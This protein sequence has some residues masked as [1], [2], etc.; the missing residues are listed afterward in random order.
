MTEKA[1]AILE[2]ASVR[3]TAAARAEQL[4]S[5]VAMTLLDVDEAETSVARER[6][7]RDELVGQAIELGVAQHPNAA[8]KSPIEH[9]MVPT[10]EWF[11]AIVDI[12]S[13]IAPRVRQLEANEQIRV[14]SGTK[15]FQV[16]AH[17]LV[18]QARDCRQVPRRN[19]QLI[20][21]IP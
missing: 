5:E 17:E 1:S 14:G 2:R 20:R 19:Q 4:V 13:R 9:R 6:R 18:A 8:R 11:R 7:R 12:G 15:P 21:I 16:P 10:R 3:P